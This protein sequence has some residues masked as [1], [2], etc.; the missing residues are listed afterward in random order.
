[1]KICFAICE[2]NPFHNGHL[3]HLEYIKE[4]IKPDAVAIIMSGDFTQR[5]EIAVLDKYTRAEHAIKA[6][7][8]VVFELP[9]IFA[10]APAEIFAKGAIS[11]INRVHGEKVLCFGTES[12]EKEKLLSTAAAL[13]NETKEFKKLYK[14]EL[15]TG[16]PSI[17]AKINALNKMNV[18]NLDFELLK[19]PNN[20]LAVEYAK[21]V[22]SYKSDVTLEPILRQGAAYD[23]AELKKG[24]SSALAIRQA[25][26]EGKLKKV[27][28]AVP[29]FVY[30]D[31]PDKLPCADD[32]IFYSLLKTPKSEMAKIL[33]C[34]EGLENRIKALACNCLTLDELKEKLKTK[35]YTYARLSRILLSCMLGIDEKLIRKSLEQELYLKVLAINKQKTDLLS[36]FD[37]NSDLP[38]IT[39]KSDAAKLDGVAAECF[40]KDVFANLVF[41]FINGKKTNEYEMKMV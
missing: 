29:G 18:E 1:M 21:A 19:S 38:L 33:D 32:I 9:A 26:T 13:I 12:A 10:A 34:N 8:D 41:D 5:G 25:I 3:K 20:I 24:V 6:G 35:R 17:K 37:K 40:K 30:A 27:K 36:Y 23:D 2:Y 7:A 14:E 11:I 4:K 31:L 15:K 22:L 39:R 16:I 28:D